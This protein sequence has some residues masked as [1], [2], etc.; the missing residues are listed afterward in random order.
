MFL[1]QALLSEEPKL[2][3]PSCMVL[4]FTVYVSIQMSYMLKMDLFLTL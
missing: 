1:S 2:Q 4:I 3:N